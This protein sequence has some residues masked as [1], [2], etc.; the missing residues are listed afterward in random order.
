MTTE[1]Q[2]MTAP[3]GLSIHLGQRT[4][5]ATHNFRGLVKLAGATFIAILTRPIVRSRL[6][7]QQVRKEVARSGVQML[8]WTTLLA[9]V[10]GTIVIGQMLAVLTRLGSHHYLGTILV[11]VVVNELA[12]LAI[13]LLVLARVGSATVIELGTARV[14]GAIDER[15]GF[16]RD[17]IYLLV[18]PQ[19]IGYSVSILCL[20]I[21][22]SALTVGFAYL[23]VMMENLPIIPSTYFRQVMAALSWESFVFLLLKSG[24][25][26]FAI[27]VTT[28]YAGLVHSA[29]IRH[30]SQ[31]T[32]RAVMTGVT[33]CVLLDAIFIIY[34]LV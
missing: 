12:P 22:L 34:H 4:L 21:Y 29:D 15:R 28:S 7:R 2:S 25:F 5:A 32:I 20:T 18:V 16:G 1:R 10:L 9:A 33:A 26:G 13:A 3:S 23:I 31:A 30:L 14:R 19:V 27:G 6:I 11:T 8:P 17:P 24:L